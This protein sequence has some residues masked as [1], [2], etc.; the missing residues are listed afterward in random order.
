MGYTIVYDKKFVKTEKGI[1]PVILSGSSNC[2]TTNSRGQD[3]RTRDWGCFRFA[4]R[5]MSGEMI[6][7]EVKKLVPTTY[8][9]HFMYNGKWVD[10]NG[11]VNFFKSGIRNALTLEELMDKYIVSCLRIEVC[12]KDI[13]STKEWPSPLTLMSASCRNNEE[14]EEA[15]ECAI[16]AFDGQP[17]EAYP[18]FRYAFGYEN[19]RLKTRRKNRRRNCK[20]A[21]TGFLLRFTN[22]DY[23][24]R[25]SSRHM[26]HSPYASTARHFRSREDA[27]RY[28][29]TELRGY[30]IAKGAT[31]VAKKLVI[32][33]PRLN[34]C[35][36][37]RK[38]WTGHGFTPMAAFAKTFSS[39]EQAEKEKTSP[40]FTIAGVGDVEI[41]T[42]Y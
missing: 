25:R 41:V 17:K 15:L 19:E 11:F 2:Y 5:P 28:C 9:E 13:E 40:Y 4:E 20:V 18:Y 12:A 31:I 16:A 23:F 10:D 39:E 6:M 33:T 14:L 8:G 35:P 36:T 7:E 29:L 21:E 27:E 3:V 38:F 22:S 26:W 32:R 24:V 34:D 37:E 30:D 1:I 42:E